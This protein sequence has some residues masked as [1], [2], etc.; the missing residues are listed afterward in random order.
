MHYFLILVEG[1]PIFFSPIKRLKEM[2]IQKAEEV[3][4]YEDMNLHM[5]FY[6]RFTLNVEK[7]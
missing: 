5:K 2:L 3:N 7:L 1:N 6:S 4:I